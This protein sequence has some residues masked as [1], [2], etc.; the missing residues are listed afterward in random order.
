MRNLKIIRII[1]LYLS[2]NRGINLANLI[3]QIMAELSPKII[4]EDTWY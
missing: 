1:I 2:P 4:V 3:T